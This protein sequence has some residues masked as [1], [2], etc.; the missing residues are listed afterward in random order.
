M[1]ENLGSGRSSV[2][3]VL[4]GIILFYF[5][6]YLFYFILF[7][8]LL[9]S[10]LS[11]SL[12]LCLSLSTYL[13]LSLS[14]LWCLSLSYCIKKEKKEK[15]IYLSARRWRRGFKSGCTPIFLYLDLFIYFV[16]Y[17]GTSGLHTQM[18]RHAWFRVVCCCWHVAVGMLYIA[19]VSS[20]FISVSQS[21]TSRCGLPS[22]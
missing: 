1:E 3:S 2:M 16:L 8:F 17:G 5:F 14:Q 6:I 20:L 18:H 22:K 13:S 10:F 9:I 4:V 21:P 15:N 12:S 11:I 19:M 7:Y